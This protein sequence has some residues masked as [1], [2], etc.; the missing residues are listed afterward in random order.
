MQGNE[1]D[2]WAVHTLDA[3]EAHRSRAAEQCHAADCLKEE[4]ERGVNWNCRVE[5]MARGPL[6]GG[7]AATEM[8]GARDEASRKK[9][10]EEW[11]RECG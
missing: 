2:D 9:T 4:R 11:M 7:E 10:R 5:G 6:R 3:N 1:R 8:S